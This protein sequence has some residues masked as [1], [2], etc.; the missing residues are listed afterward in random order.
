M[1]ELL[2]LQEEMTWLNE[3]RLYVAERIMELL[4]SESVP[5]TQQSVRAQTKEMY[6]TQGDRKNKS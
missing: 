6:L 1:S 3:R 5:T 2:A 4:F